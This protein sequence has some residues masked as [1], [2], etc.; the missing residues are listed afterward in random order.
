MLRTE[1]FEHLHGVTHIQFRGGTLNPPFS[2]GVSVITSIDVVSR[3]IPYAEA[4]PTS[5]DDQ[6]PT[7]HVFIRIGRPTKSATA[8][9]RR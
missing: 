7:Q 5:Y 3:E 2:C 8:K 9:A 4:L 6:R 1:L